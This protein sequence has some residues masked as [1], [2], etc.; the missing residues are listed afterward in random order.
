[1]SDLKGR[2][3]RLMRLSGSGMLFDGATMEDLATWGY[4]GSPQPPGD[5]PRGVERCATFLSCR[6]ALLSILAGRRPG[7]GP[8][9]VQE[10]AEVLEDLELLEDAPVETIV[11]TLMAMGRE[12]RFTPAEMDRLRDDLAELVNWRDPWAA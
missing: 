9:D 11:S 5:P 10:A 12:D 3:R 4:T 2:I 6:A 1:M 8:E 7:A